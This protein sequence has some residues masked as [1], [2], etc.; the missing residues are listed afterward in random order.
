VTRDATSNQL[1]VKPAVP[2]EPLHVRL[3]VSRVMSEDGKV[4]AQWLLL[5]N[6]KED[7]SASTLAL[8]YYRRWR[9]ESFFKL[10]KSEGH[11]LE[12][13]Q[14]ESAQAVAKRLLV[15]SMACV[16]VWAIAADQST[17]AK[18]RS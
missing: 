14:Q 1:K 5:S 13:W 9:I 11:E 8:W 12:A 2:G 16:T 15:A 3:V 6:V 18:R 4:L 17:E 7:V 10:L